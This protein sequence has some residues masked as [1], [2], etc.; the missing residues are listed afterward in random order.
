M[1]FALWKA[2]KPGE[3][4]W[5]SPWGL[6]RPGWHIECS[7]MSSHYL[8]ESLISTAGARTSF[9]PIMKTNWPSPL[10]AHGKPLARYWIHNGFVTIQGE[11]M[12]KSLGNFLTIQEMLGR[13]H[14]EA[15]RLVSPFLPLSFP[16]GLFGPGPAE[17]QSHL[18]RLYRLFQDLENPSERPQTGGER[19]PFASK[20]AGNS[21]P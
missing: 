20:K 8:G 14:P 15:L 2:V 13:C 7:A 17:A 6:G 16:L 21:R 4:A 5:E 3:P 18:Q 19:K 9:S 12:S 1:D 10:A 11:K